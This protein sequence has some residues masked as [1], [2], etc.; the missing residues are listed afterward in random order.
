[1]VDFLDFFNLEI[2]SIIIDYLFWGYNYFGWLMDDGQY[3][4]MADEN[5]GYDIK[6]I[7]VSDFCEF[8]VIGIFDV[9]INNLMSIIYNQIVACDYLYV[10]YYY[11]GIVV[12][13]ILDLANLEKVLYYDIFNE[14][15]GI[16]YKG[17]WGIYLF[18]FFGNILVFD[19]QEGLFVFEGMGDNCVVNQ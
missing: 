7:D 15:N 14:F 16:S 3:Y 12:Y 11:D 5:Y 13:D 17:V 4:Y 19:M 2:I 18:L 10:F 1:M 9:E 6:V 8:E